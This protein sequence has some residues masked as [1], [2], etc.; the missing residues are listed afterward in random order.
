[1]TDFNILNRAKFN[2][3]RKTFKV[4]LQPFLH[5]GGGILDLGGPNNVFWVK[6][7]SWR[8][9]YIDVG[10]PTARQIRPIKKI[11]VGVENLFQNSS[12]PDGMIDTALPPFIEPEPLV[13][14][15]HFRV[16]NTNLANNH[17]LEVEFLLD[18]V[19]VVPR[20]DEPPT[21]KQMKGYVMMDSTD[22]G[23]LAMD[24]DAADQLDELLVKSGFGSL[25]DV[26]PGGING[27]KQLPPALQ[28]P[29]LQSLAAKGDIPAEFVTPMLALGGAGAPP[30]MPGAPPLALPDADPEK[31]TSAF[32]GDLLACC[33]DECQE[34]LKTS[35][36]RQ[37]ATAMV[38][39]GWRRM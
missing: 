23:R 26:L 17:K 24:E 32:L 12:S 1:M 30:G 20:T 19:L 37:I 7:V 11:R 13:G 21:L 22:R 28:G 9:E 15:I 5:Q 38:E 3:M 8:Y 10:I 2:D 29:V 14:K 31:E 6:R 18:G 27:L 35:H 36:L 33:P 34:T 4:S 16:E 25:R 39:K